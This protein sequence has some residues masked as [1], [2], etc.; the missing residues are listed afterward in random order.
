MPAAARQFDLTAHPGFISATAGTTVRINQLPAA[1]VGDVHTCV[2][3]PLAGPHPPNTITTGSSTVRI[4][5]RAAARQS[6][7]TACGAPITTGAPNVT[8]GG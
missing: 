6:D 1:T 4:S 7:L 2:L 3:P 8:I 5:K